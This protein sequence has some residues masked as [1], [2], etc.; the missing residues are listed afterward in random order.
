MRYC[1]QGGNSFENGCRVAR[2]YESQA[3][4]NFS[5]IQEFMNL[6]STTP[7]FW[8]CVLEKL[9]M[10]TATS[11]LDTLRECEVGEGDVEQKYRDNQSVGE[12]RAG[13]EW[14]AVRLVRRTFLSFK[15]LYSYLILNFASTFQK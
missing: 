14:E 4:T 7:T 15:P 1:L 8:V 3:E 9:P 10:A 11:P 2:G 12:V 6:V 5:K 13:V